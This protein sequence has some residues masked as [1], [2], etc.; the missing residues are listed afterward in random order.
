MATGFGVGIQRLGSFGVATK[1][2]LLALP[3]P[4]ANV[5]PTGFV[6]ADSTPSNNGI[7]TWTGAVW[8][9]SRGLLE[10][11]ASLTVTG[12]TAN[13]ITA[14]AQAGVDLSQIVV[15]LL[16][17]SLTN[18]GAVTLN[19]RAVT[20]A[21]GTALASGA[22]AAGKVYLLWDD[23]TK[24]RAV[25]NSFVAISDV[26][27]LTAALAAKADDAATTAALAGKADATATTS[28]LAGKVDRAGGTMT[29]D[30]TV[31]LG[32]STKQ[33]SDTMSPAGKIGF[34]AQRST[35]TG[36]LKANGA[37]VSRT[38]Y[39]A[40]WAALLSTA[41]VTMTI[42][43]PGVITWTGHG[44]V[45]N[46]P[47]RFTTTGALPTGLTANTTYF[48]VGASI[49]ANTFQVSATAGGAAIATSG[50]QS[51]TH[52]GL[53]APFGFGDGSTTFNLPDLR[54]EF[55]RGFDD[56][57]GIDTNRNFGSLQLDA[58]QGHFHA[59]SSRTDLVTS[60]GSNG[61]TNGAGASATGAPITDGTNGTPRIAAET[62]PR[63]IAL[64]ACIKF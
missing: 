23:G 8:S 14:T 12:G 43:T 15:A 6:Y 31:A 49:T 1:A 11:M 53:F 4:G 30:P 60:G 13:A 17:P 41:T 57:R 38:T 34:F 40:L 63:N 58:F 2:A 37:A 26:S 10:Q 36:W 35:P 42:A 7:Y 39:A 55:P 44:F 3:S 64:L 29:A 5:R 62:R 22:L 52:T 19:G 16:V 33:Y 46:D 50:T 45:A 25:Y 47:V 9:R 48:V 32:V 18:T 54:G 21:A 28:A 24:Y 20:D 27:G 51:G 59:M 61:A 56:G